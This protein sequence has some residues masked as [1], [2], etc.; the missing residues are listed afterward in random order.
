MSLPLHPVM[1]HLPLALALLMPLFAAFAAWGLWTGRIH[2]RGWLAIAAL[3]LLLVTTAVVA[4]KTGE[5][6]EDRVEAVVPDGALHQHE[7]YA[8]QFTWGAVA[9][10]GLTLLAF[11]PRAS[12]SVALVS[13][14]GTIAV[15]GLA[16][17]VGHAGGQL[18]YVHNAGAAYTAS[19]G[20]RAAGTTAASRGVTPN[21]PKPEGPKTPNHDGRDAEGEN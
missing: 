6:E 14:V 15:A 10:L 7:A 1:V 13:I 8:E 19:A 5:R 11:V 21:L 9:V 12:R 2:R 18:V 16:L 17:R 3:Q 20:Q 4:M